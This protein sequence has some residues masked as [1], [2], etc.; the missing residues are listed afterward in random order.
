MANNVN[1]VLMANNNVSAILIIA[2]IGE[3]YK[4]SRKQW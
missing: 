4:L 1:I 2:G 3:I